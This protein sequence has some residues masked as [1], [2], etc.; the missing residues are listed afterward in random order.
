M[1]YKTVLIMSLSLILLTGCLYPQGNLAK[2]ELANDVQLE[3]VEKAVIQYQEETGGLL[4][5]KTKPSDT[6]LYEKYLID[7][8]ALKDRGIITET[9]GTAYENGGVY[10]YVIINPEEDLKVKVLDLRTTEQL[11]AVNIQ[12]DTYRSKHTYPPLGEEI[13]EGVY[14]LNYELIGM[15][16]EPFITSPYSQTELPFVMDHTGQ[17]YIDYSVDLYQALNEFDHNYVEGDNILPILADNYPFVPAYSLPVTIREGD[18]IF[19]LE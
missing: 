4:P 3:L 8:L 18:P 17:V 2:N 14:K 7:F 9:P 1:K 11:R 16:E 19:N 6:A 12:I 10:Q 13:A 15:K 5:I